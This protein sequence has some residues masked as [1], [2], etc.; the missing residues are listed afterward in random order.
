ML[1]LVFSRVS[2]AGWRGDLLALLAGLLMPLAYAPFNLY[3]FAILL[4][5][6]LFM[7]WL[8][9]LPGRAFIRGLL[10]G[11][12]M[13]GAGTTWMYISIHHFGH[14]NVPLSLFIL[15]LMV[16]FMALFYA[17]LGYLFT[18]F[19]HPLSLKLKLVIV[20]PAAWVFLEWVRGWFMTGF[21]W[22][23]LGYSQVDSLLSS[24]A[25][26]LGVYGVSWVVALSAGLLLF[27]VM[28]KSWLSGLAIVALWLLAAMMGQITWT[29]P[30]GE[31][32]KVSLIQGNIAQ[33][34]KWLAEMRMP[35]IER[36]SRLTREN[37]QSDLIVWPESA[38]PDFRYRV[39]D[40]LEPLGDEAKANNSQLLIG[41]LSVQMEPVRYYNS[42][43]GLGTTEG[44]Y[45]KQH[46]VPFTEYLPMKSLLSDIVDFMDVPMSD[47]SSGDDDQILMEVNGHKIGLS[48]CYEAVFGEELITSLPEASMLVNVSNDGWFGES[49]GPHQHLQIIRMRALETGRFVLRST[50]T[51]IS[52]IIGPDGKIQSASPQFE[53]HVLTDEVQPMQGATPYVVWGNWMVIILVSV[54]LL[55]AL[56]V[57]R[58]THR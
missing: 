39:L 2:R 18:R 32:V 17:L 34:E 49:I 40:V 11:A 8:D 55:S 3:P 50:N 51:G 7:T 10:F 14:V 36:Y 37:W 1:D 6:L 46:L 43:V 48:I 23:N 52:A 29:T 56:I 24:F 27:A 30:E 26:V 44:I 22:L 47:F 41:V 35:T 57:S 31:P 20:L 4:P 25:P 33:D 28:K 15:A 45:H 13:F 38:L 19:F 12:A 54:S 58:R 42:V 53:V 16:M 9:V 5:A 21:P